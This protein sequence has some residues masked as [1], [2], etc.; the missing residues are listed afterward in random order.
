MK[1]LTIGRK[2]KIANP[3]SI[4]ARFWSED[5]GGIVG[6]GYQIIDRAL[7]DGDCYVVSLAHKC[8]GQR[9]LIAFGSPES[10]QAMWLDISALEKA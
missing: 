2:V 4:A 10:N 1:R 3:V 8:K 5:H 7:L 9:G 6:A